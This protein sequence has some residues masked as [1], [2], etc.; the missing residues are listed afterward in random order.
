ME[1]QDVQVSLTAD[2][3]NMPGPLSSFATMMLIHYPALRI[4]YALLRMGLDPFDLGKTEGAVSWKLCG[5]GTGF[6]FSARPYWSRYALFAAWESREAWEKF[7]HHSKVTARFRKY[8]REVWWVAL[9]PIQSRGSW[10]GKALFKVGTTYPSG[11]VAVLTR[12]TIRWSRLMNFWGEVESVS[13]ALGKAK[14]LISSVGFG[15]IPWKRQATFSVWESVQ[16]FEAFAYGDENH[17]RVI[18]RTRD[19]GWYE[20]EMFARFHPIES[21]GSWNG[22]DPLRLKLTS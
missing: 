18:Q 6:G 13:A 15:E 4:P 10:N 5:T 16:A 14:G 7:L 20:E 22:T 1:G 19:E 2:L 8:A 9:T 11:P 12:A 21:G 17:R 3:K